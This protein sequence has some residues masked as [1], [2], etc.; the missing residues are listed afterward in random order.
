ML[1]SMPAL[2]VRA[3]GCAPP[4]SLSMAGQGARRSAAC[5]LQSLKASIL[6]TREKFVVLKGSAA[7]CSWQTETLW[8]S[9]Q[10]RI[11]CGGTMNKHAVIGKQLHEHYRWPAELSPA[12]ISV[13]VSH[14]L[15]H[16]PSVMHI[17]TH[18]VGKVT[19]KMQSLTDY[20][21]FPHWL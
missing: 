17:Q 11:I 10:C 21:L 6:R 3:V 7:H 18:K 4:T 16:Y 5:G 1:S 14:T 13:P 9:V 8:H 12:A 2:H 15:A 20:G 19:S